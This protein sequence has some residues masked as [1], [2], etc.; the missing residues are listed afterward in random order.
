MVAGYWQTAAFPSRYWASGYWPVY[1]TGEPEVVTGVF[2][3][4]FRRRRR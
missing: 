4:T 2:L 1:G 3:P